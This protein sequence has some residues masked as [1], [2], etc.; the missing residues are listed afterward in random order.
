M[1]CALCEPRAPAS[2]YFL[3][4]LGFLVSFLRS[5]PLAIE[6]ISLRSDYASALPNLHT[7][8]NGADERGHIGPGTGG[9]PGNHKK[10]PLLKFD[11]VGLRP[12][13]LLGV[14]SASGCTKAASP[15]VGAARSRV[16]RLPALR[17]RAGWQTF[18]GGRRLV[19]L[20][21]PRRR[22]RSGQIRFCRKSAA[23]ASC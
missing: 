6:K 4:F 15:D 23:R 9:P 20:Q 7:L 19:R 11:C 5:I 10:V 12:R 16:H 2:G 13:T 14:E 18:R 17:R 22:D 3:S 8:L 21:G 1:H